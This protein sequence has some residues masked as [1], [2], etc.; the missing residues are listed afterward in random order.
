[1]KKIMNQREAFGLVGKTIYREKSD[2][3][4]WTLEEECNGGY[5]ARNEE[6]GEEKILTRGDLKGDYICD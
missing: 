1:M 2:C 4:Y 3:S 6:T 5:W